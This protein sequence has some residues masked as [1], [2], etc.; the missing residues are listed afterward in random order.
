MIGNQVAEYN[1]SQLDSITF[2]TQK[3]VLH[4]ANKQIAEYSAMQLDSITFVEGDS[5]GSSDTT[6]PSVTGDAIDITNN[7]ATLVGYATNIRDNLSTDLR[8]GFIY[9]LEGTPNKNNGT[10][11][12]VPVEDVAEDGRFVATLSNLLS[13]TIY[14]FRSFVYQSGLWFYGKVKSFMTKS[15]DVDLNTGNA[16]AITCFSAKVSGRVCVQSLYSTLEYGLCYGTGIEPTI[17]ENKVVATSKTFTLQLR[18]LLGGTTYYYRSYA[19]VDGLTY[20]GTVRT[21]CTLDDNV[22]ETGTIDEESLTVISRL[23]IGG[24]AYSSLVLGV[25]FGGAEL[26]TINDYTVTTDEV[27]DENKYKVQLVKLDQDIIY[28]R[29]YILID[30]VPHYG[31]VKSFKR[32]QDVGSYTLWNLIKRNPNFSRFADIVCHAKYYKDNTHPVST[33][34]YAD[35]LNGGQ[36]NTVWV[37]DNDALTEGEYQKWLQMCESESVED[38]YIVQLQ[39]LGNH[40]ALWR[41]SISEPGVEM[42]RMINGKNL[43][44][45]KVNLTLEGLPLGDDYNIPAVNGV[46]H[47]LKGVAPFHYNFYEYLKYS[48]PQTKLG[49]YVI[50]KDTTYFSPDLSIEG[51]PDENGNP[52]YVDSVFRTTNHLLETTH[53]IPQNNNTWLMSKNGFGAHIGKEDSLFVMLLPT[54]AAWDATY[55]KLKEAHIYASKYEDKN[56]GNINITAYLDVPDVDSLQKMSTEMDMISPLV[57]DIHKQPKINDQIMWTLDEFKTDKGARAEYLLNTFG[58]TLRNIGD[59]DKA[60]LFGDVEPIEMSNGLAYEV[61]SWN[62]PPEYYTP[63]VEVEIEDTDIFYNKNSSKHRVGSSSKKYLFSNEIFKDITDIYG[64]VSNDN[65]YH[66]DA[67]GPTSGPK[68]EIKLM[69]NSF[70]AYVPNAQVMNGKYDIQIVVVPHWYLEVAK[71]TEINYLDETK[72]DSAANVNK[73]KIRA[74]LTYNNGADTDKNQVL[75]TG[76]DYDGLRVDTLTLCENFEFPYSYKNLRY[77]YPTLY[78]ES[79]ASKNDANRNGFVYDL[80]IDK[81]I[82]KRKK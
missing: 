1:T 8:V 68:V 74:T 20:Y 44:F 30:G 66:L 21:F 60:T 37:P 54:D 79:V 77:S 49:R 53:Y 40:I 48:N 75:S 2:T 47:V 25:C 35:I 12:D 23:T 3:A 19:I 33:Y 27:D 67:P 71:G 17:E 59:W 38:G 69:G 78:V 5:S 62:F 63:D 7:S 4:L 36:V 26:P 82:L 81:I 6:D 16:T 14:Y 73:Y 65:F 72:A 15:T 34:T 28:Y 29:A 10:Q 18:Q 51:L 46:M 64:K 76:I 56:K 41:H 70:N 39:F 9:S 58:D 80:V 13:N 42:V 61:S 11:V 55:E 31:A 43:E 57:F 52:T 22:V 50:S 24:G 32:E 45:D